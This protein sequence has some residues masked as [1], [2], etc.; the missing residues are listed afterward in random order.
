MRSESEHPHA[1]RAVGTARD[2]SRQCRT[3]LCQASG[4]SE[5]PN[6]FP[7]GHRRE[8]QNQKHGHCKRDGAPPQREWQLDFLERQWT[9]SCVY[10]NIEIRKETLRAI[11]TGHTII[12]KLQSKPTI[13]SSAHSSL[14]GADGS[15]VK[16]GMTNHH[17]SPG[18]RAGVHSSYDTRSALEDM[19]P[20]SEAGMTKETAGMTYRRPG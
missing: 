1:H 8:A 20:V 13:L 6:H 16:P 5:C 10:S 11:K 4:R 17:L 19:D 15:R 18:P 12:S 9:V 2:G 7:L 14:A 3:W